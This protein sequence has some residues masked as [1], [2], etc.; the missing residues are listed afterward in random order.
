M[1]MEKFWYG[2]PEDRKLKDEGN[3][4]YGRKACNK[5]NC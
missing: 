5:Y 1:S 4:Y 3:S 2:A